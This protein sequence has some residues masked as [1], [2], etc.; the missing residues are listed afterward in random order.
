MTQSRL[1]VAER[2]LGVLTALLALATGLLAY[3]TATVTQAKDQAQVAAADRSTDLS[4]LRREYDALKSENEDTQTENARLRTQL[5]LGEPTA[6]PQPSAAPSVRHRGQIALASSGSKL[7]L[8]APESDPQWGGDTVDIGFTGYQLRFHSGS[9]ALILKDVNADY[10]SCRER[11][12]YSSS[13]H[14]QR[15]APAR[16][17][18]M[19]EDKR[20]ALLRT[21]ADRYQLEHRDVR[22]CDLRPA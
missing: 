8:D 11:T 19:R 13:L 5:G 22:C 15:L 10:N 6:Q 2:V 12:G 1:T 7:N 3:R 18:P 21:A 14:R 17:L 4:S 16:Y 20:Q 9:Q